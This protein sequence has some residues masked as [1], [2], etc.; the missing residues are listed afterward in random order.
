MQ[1]NGI[2]TQKSFA[3]PPELQTTISEE[4]LQ[5]LKDLNIK[6]ATDN[7]KLSDKLCIVEKQLKIYSEEKV[8]NE[9]MKIK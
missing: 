6:L 8:K 3:S 2:K 5:N 7:R 1:L 9:S 4:D